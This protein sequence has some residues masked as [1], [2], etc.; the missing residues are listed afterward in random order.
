M[1]AGHV[2][3]GEDLA[4]GAFSS[5]TG[6]AIDYVRQYLTTYTLEHGNLFGRGQECTTLD[7]AACHAMRD[8]WI[9][10]KNRAVKCL[11]L[12]RDM[13]KKFETGCSYGVTSP[14]RLLPFLRN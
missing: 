12:L 8:V 11:N 3:G 10:V 5:L 4:F 9:E 2:R 13:Q 14:S 1:W 7:L 6:L